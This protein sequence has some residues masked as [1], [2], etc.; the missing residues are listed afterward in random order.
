MGNYNSRSRRRGINP[1]I[2]DWSGQYANL[3]GK[4]HEKH[5][6]FE[7]P[8]FAEARRFYDSPAYQQARAL[9]AGAAQATFVLVEGAGR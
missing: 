3:E 5:V 2:L 8:S 1:D 9:R 4:S 7:F 6:I